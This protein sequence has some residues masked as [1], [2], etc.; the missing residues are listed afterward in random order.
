MAI[1]LLWSMQ[2]WAHRPGESYVY[3]DVAP[4]GISGELHIRLNDFGKALPLDADGDGVVQ[5]EEFARAKGEALAYLDGRL[6]FFASGV[7]HPPQFGAM[8]YF[9][10]P[11]DMLVAI[12]FDLPTLGPPP[13]VMEAEYRFL[14]DGPMPEHGAMLIQASSY[15]LG[16]SDNEAMP[17]LIF[18]RGAERQSLDLR[19]RPGGDVFSDFVSHGIQQIL[20]RLPHLSILAILLLPV[21]MHRSGGSWSPR[22]TPKGMAGAVTIALAL[23]TVG[24][25][26][27]AVLRDIDALDIGRKSTF[28]A[29]AVAAGFVAADNWRPFSF[30]SR[31]VV[32]AVSGVALGLASSNYSN[33]IALD[34]GLVETALAGFGL[35]VLISSLIVA[36]FMVPLLWLARSSTL[37]GTP[38]LRIGTL[39][40]AAVAVIGVAS[41]IVMA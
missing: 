9:G 40:L 12:S 5:P 22:A 31:P 15:K 19:P 2:A 34:R 7:E 36:A 11:G 25:V 41:R 24:L 37:F 3:I 10:N 38:A 6:R 23:F 35:G 33:R 39:S 27:G 4:D 26:A 1:V 8:R 18:G 14:Y 28:A 30:M 17:S 16:V 29:I 13:D 21:V 32:A 20:G